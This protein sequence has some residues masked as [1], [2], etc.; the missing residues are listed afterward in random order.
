MTRAWWIALAVAACQ[1]T[2]GGSTSGSASP[3]AAPPAQ[4]PQPA[5]TDDP[6]ALH[7]EFTA[8]LFEAAERTC[9]CR[10]FRCARAVQ[11]DL[12]RWETTFGHANVQGVPTHEEQ[13]ALV[14][15]MTC[16]NRIIQ[17]NRPAETSS[18]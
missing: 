15:L 11:D 18:P 10:D 14:Q 4:Q 8:K 13:R 3:P 5:S 12:A 1:S 6:E 9:A 17:A 2:G 7:A 16:A